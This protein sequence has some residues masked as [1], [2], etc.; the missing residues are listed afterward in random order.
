MM[1]DSM[2]T[3]E[4]STSSLSTMLLIRSMSCRVAKI[5]SELLRSSAMIFVW[6]KIWI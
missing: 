5:S 6:P 1:T 4:S 2:S 3:C